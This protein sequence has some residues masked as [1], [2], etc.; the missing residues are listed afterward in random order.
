MNK[1]AQ[2]T[3]FV[4][5]GLLILIGSGIYIFVKVSNQTSEKQTAIQVA[6]IP[7]EFR[8]IS[9]YVE[10]CIINVGKD[11]L[12]LLGF[13]GGYIDLNKYGIQP[14][15]ATPTQAK[16]FLFNSQDSKSGIVFWNYFQSDNKCEQNCQ[17]ASEQPYLT[18]NE[19][20]PNIETQL[21]DYVEENLDIC[22]AGFTPFKSQG[23]DIKTAGNVQAT[24]N[25]RDDDVLFTV[26]YAVE[27]KRGNDNFKIENFIRPINLKLKKIYTLADEIRKTEANYSYLERWTVEQIA[28]FGLGAKEDRLPP[29][30]SSELDPGKNPTYWV[31]AQVQDDIT[32]NMLPI[33]TPF[34]SAF[35]TANYKDN[36]RGTFY[37]RAT[38]PINSTNLD[39]S[40]FDVKF[41]YLNW[42]PIY[43]DITGRGVSGQ[44]LGP[45]T[46]SSSLLSFIGVKRYNFYYDV[47][48]PVLVDVYD[49]GAFDFEGYHFYIGLES[50]VR[51]NEPLNCSGPGLTQYAVPSGSLFCNDN[52]GCANI[53]IETKDAKTGQPLANSSL[54]YSSGTE[55]CDKGITR[56]SGNQAL[57]KVSL[58]QCVGSACSLNIVKDGYWS[59][60]TTYAVRCDQTSVCSNEN[61]L[62]NGESVQLSME[63]FRNT[64]IVV[65][66]KKMLK[67][68]QKTWA[69]SGEA[70]NLL[71][72]EYS[73]ISLTKIKDNPYETDLVLNGIYYG[74]QTSTKILPGLIPGNYQLRIDLFYKL[75]DSKQRNIITFQAVEEC[76]D[77]YF[78]LSEDCTTVGPYNFTQDF[79]EGGYIAN[80]TLTK[81]MVDSNRIIFYALSSPDIDTAYSVLDVYDLDEMTKLE[82]YSNQY[83]VELKPISG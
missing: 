11:G 56:Q 6:E 18:K 10:T 58:P 7:V 48:Y 64:S 78:G 27:A 31:K 22:L 55:S 49:S 60:P 29:M 8:P 79:I 74:N 1:K 13:H 71:S 52:Q 67:Q 76:E 30:A 26:R 24:V 16:A 34:L 19:G 17:C 4:I 42:W 37:E 68:S 14:N 51:N 50:N 41:N 21:E 77:T 53:T 28:G 40:S 23:Y 5:I 43:F 47:S 20:S 65:M 12:K 82:N 83:K 72:N 57:A 81:E 66:K 59:Y 54:Y 32:N 33:Y 45:E 25:I 63:P 73:M 62:C 36:L 69:F 70:T 9:D 38:V 46:A 15:G 75:P 35:G 39:Y 44:K 61:V 80:I 2:V 3:L